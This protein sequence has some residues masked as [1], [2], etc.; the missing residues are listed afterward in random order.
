MT[1][2]PFGKLP[3]TPQMD[4]FAFYH[5]MAKVLKSLMCFLKKRE[6]GLF[7]TRATLP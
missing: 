2:E 6:A 3:K 4:H 7:W 1:K 5:N